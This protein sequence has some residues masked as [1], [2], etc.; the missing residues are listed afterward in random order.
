MTGN[1][2]LSVRLGHQST[3]KCSAV[4]SR[5]EDC[6]RP[7]TCLVYLTVVCFLCF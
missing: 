3:K 2:Y 6:P 1:K 4:S 5:K 7:I